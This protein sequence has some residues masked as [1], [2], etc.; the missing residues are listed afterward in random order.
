MRVKLKKS[1]TLTLYL[2]SVIAGVEQ[3]TMEQLMSEMNDCCAAKV[4]LNARLDYDNG[5]IEDYPKLYELEGLVFESFIE[6]LKENDP[7]RFWNWIDLLNE[8][9]KHT[10]ELEIQ[11]LNI[12]NPTL[13][14]EQLQTFL[15]MYPLKTCAA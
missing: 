13:S 10:P 11:C 8:E 1:K 9:K 12:Q 5:L 4:M 2:T 3:K 15:A 6:Y 14:S 7:E